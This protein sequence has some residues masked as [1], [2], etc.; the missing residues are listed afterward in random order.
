MLGRRRFLL[1]LPAAIVGAR[2]ILVEPPKITEG[3]IT[4]LWQALEGRQLGAGGDGGFIVPQQFAAALTRTVRAMDEMR[5][6]A[7]EE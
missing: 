1:S 3:A 4:D 5:D 2:R 7:E 6:L